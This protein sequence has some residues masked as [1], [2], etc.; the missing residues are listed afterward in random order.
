MEYHQLAEDDVHAAVEEFLQT[1][2]E[3]IPDSEFDRL[4]DS[5]KE[6]LKTVGTF[7]EGTREGADFVAS[8]YVDKI[9]CIAVSV[10][11][12][13]PKDKLIEAARLAQERS[14]RPYVLV[15]DLFPNYMASLPSAL[16]GTLP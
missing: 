3:T 16:V 14:H 11:D 15:F 7:N 1:Q 13:F 10:E 2:P 5:T 8:R 6:A 9:P 4:F 12:D